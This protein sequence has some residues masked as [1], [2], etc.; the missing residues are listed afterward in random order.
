MNSSNNNSNKFIK[1]PADTKSIL[2]FYVGIVE[3]TDIKTTFLKKVNITKQTFIYSDETRDAKLKSKRLVA[4][5]EL[6]EMFNDKKTV[7]LFST[8]IDLVMEMITKNIFRPLPTLKKGVDMAETGV[9]AEGLESDPSW[10]HIKGIYE[11]FLQLVMCEACDIKILKAFV[12][13]NF[14]ADVRL[15]F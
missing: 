5:N 9:E 13:G 1:K 11:I 6:I 3:K 7:E 2:I 14:L 15:L 4:I 10:A 8:H 12:T